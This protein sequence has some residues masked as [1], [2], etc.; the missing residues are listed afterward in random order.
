MTGAPPRYTHPDDMTIT[1]YQ[2][3]VC[4]PIILRAIAEGMSLRGICKRKDLPSDSHFLNWVREDKELAK[5]YAHAR[6]AQADGFVDEIV[7]ISDNKS[8]DAARDRLRIDARKWVAGKQRPRVYG[9]KATTEINLHEGD[10]TVQILNAPQD[11][12][13]WLAEVAQRLDGGEK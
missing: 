11:L 5:H 8:G 1:K 3:S 2:P 6:E 12:K 10:K 7:A 13:A 9:D 4:V